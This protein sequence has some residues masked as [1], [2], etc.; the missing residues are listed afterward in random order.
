MNISNGTN[1]RF[2]SCRIACSR[3]F[4]HPGGAP[5]K[6]RVRPLRALAPRSRRGTPPGLAGRHQTVLLTLHFG[7]DAVDLRPILRRHVLSRLAQRSE[8]LHRSRPLFRSPHR[9]RPR[10][11]SGA[12]ADSDHRS[13]PPAAHAGGR[14]ACLALSCARRPTQPLDAEDRPMT[15]DSPASRPALAPVTGA[16]GEGQG[17]LPGAPRNAPPGGSSLPPSLMLR[18]EDAKRPPTHPP[19]RLRERPRRQHH[20]ARTFA[21]SSAPKRAG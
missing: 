18:L 20:R 6:G 19:P 10:P 13:R 1:G 9:S 4:R 2:L 8:P 14:T 12:R 5:R 21:A 11:E 15:A 3:A 16:G 17:K 7:L